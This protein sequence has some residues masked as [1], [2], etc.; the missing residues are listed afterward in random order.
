MNQEFER[1]GYRD[2]GNDGFLSV[3]T[4]DILVLFDIVIGEGA[5]GLADVGNVFVRFFQ[6]PVSKKGRCAVSDEAVSFHL[7]KS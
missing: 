6:Q 1:V 4:A 5:A 2:R 3:D 7:S